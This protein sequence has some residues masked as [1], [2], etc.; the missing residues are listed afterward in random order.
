MTISVKTIR[1][2]LGL[3]LTFSLIFLFL[4]ACSLTDPDG[5]ALSQPGETESAG[6][7]QDFYQ[8]TLE[9]QFGNGIV[10]AADW[11]PDGSS[12]ALVT[13][14]QVDVYDAATLDLIQTI[15][16][17]MWNQEVAYSPDSRYLAV[18]GNDKIIQIWDLQSQQLVHSLVS[19]GPQTYYGSYLSFAFSENGQKLVSAH[20]QTVYLWDVQ[21]GKMLEVFP[22]HQYGINSVVLSP[23]ETIVLAGGSSRI[24]VRDTTSGELLYPPI[25]VSGDLVS[26]YFLPDG[27]R[28]LTVHSKFKYDPN[29]YISSYDN[30]IRRWDLSTGE[31]TGEYLVGDKRINATE[32]NPA[33]NSLILVDESGFRIWDYSTQ[34]EIISL[35]DQTGHLLS[36]EK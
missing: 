30:R 14:L 9:D 33:R 22:G 1:K 34:K 15:D 35:T 27:E 18:G 28:F 3:L 23:D 17:G 26:L 19:T 10:E 6:S 21:T 20:H 31:M 36:F 7:G 5:S 32:I 4:L 29:S 24:Y 16:T 12:F 11:A 13:S 8:F 25:E 2:T